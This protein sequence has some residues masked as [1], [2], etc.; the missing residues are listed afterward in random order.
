[1]QMLTHYQCFS[2]FW[3]ATCNKYI[4][5]HNPET[6][7]IILLHN[8]EKR[9]IILIILTT[10]NILLTFF[11]SFFK[12]VLV[13]T[14]CK[15]VIDNTKTTVLHYKLHDSKNLLFLSYYLA[16]YFHSIY[17]VL[18]SNELISSTT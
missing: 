14:I 4:L 1:M 11:I 7:D 9:D 8:P 2:N 6:R 10:K 5:L 18:D 3:N 12:K 17:A 15:V 16:Q 13:G